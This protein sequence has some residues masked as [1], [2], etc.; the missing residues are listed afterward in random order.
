M[1]N[2]DM[3]DTDTTSDSMT[4]SRESSLVGN[5]DRRSFLRWGFLVWFIFFAWLAT[6][7]HL[8]IRFMFPRVLYEPEPAFNAGLLSGYAEPDTVYATFKEAKDVWMVRLTE[9]GEERLIA[10]STVCT[11][12]GCRVNWLDDTQ[13]FKCPCHGSG[14]HMNGVHFEGPAPRPLERYRISLDGSGNVI[15]DRSVRYRRERKEWGRPGSYVRV[16]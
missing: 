3:S 2:D 12:L 4:T 14:F 8:F 9:N 6:T 1:G 5:P 15:V 13:K 10:I 11:H 16:G 7:L